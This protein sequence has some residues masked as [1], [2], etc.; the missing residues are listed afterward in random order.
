MANYKQV[1]KIVMQPE[2]ADLRNS[3]D[4]SILQR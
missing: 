3:A 4:D 1:M 2:S